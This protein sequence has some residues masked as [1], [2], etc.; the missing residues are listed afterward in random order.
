[1]LDLIKALNILLKYTDVEYPTQC[2]HDLLYIGHGVNPKDMK[3]D[4]LDEFYNLGFE[5]SPELQCFFSYK[6]G[7]C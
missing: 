7:S 3:V 1:M 4:D 2:E 6:F 5:Y